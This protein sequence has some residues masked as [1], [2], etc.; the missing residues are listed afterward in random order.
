MKR[1]V[2]LYFLFLA[3]LFVFF[4]A[5]TSML[6]TLFNDGQTKLTLYF[7]DLFLQPGQLQGIDIWINPHYKIIINKACNGVIPILFLFASILAY[8]SENTHKI[9]WMFIGY[10]VFSVVNVIRILLVV[11]VTEHGEGQGEFYWSH[12]I[13]GNFILMV[14]GL[15]LFIVFIK[16]SAK[17]VKNSES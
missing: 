8:P 16:T 4:Y 11:Y 7:L 1:F 14:T 13:V 15:V 9:L 6:S 17:R 10:V 5:P 2:A 3:L 12:D